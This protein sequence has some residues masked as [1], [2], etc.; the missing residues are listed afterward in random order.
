MPTASLP[1]ADLV[2]HLR[3]HLNLSQEKFAAKL[4]VSF[5]TV[6][7]WEK[8]H[9]LPSPMALKLIEDLLKTI[10]E[11]GKALL[12]EYFPEGKSDV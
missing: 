4:G 7:R 8:G 6:N 1:I 5:K 11:A 3:Q 9:S 10:G 12:E 2:R